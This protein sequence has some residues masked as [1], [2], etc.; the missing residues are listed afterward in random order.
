M[1]LKCL[2]SRLYPSPLPALLFII[3]MFIS[4]A[5]TNLVFSA[6]SLPYLKKKIIIIKK[7]YKSK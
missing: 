2:L 3:V 5:V 4:I 7:S 1:Y 6:P